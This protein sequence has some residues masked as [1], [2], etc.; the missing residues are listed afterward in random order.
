MVMNMIQTCTDQ[1]NDVTK[2]RHVCT[3][4][5]TFS[6]LTPNVDMEFN[7]VGELAAR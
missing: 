1:K 3:H 5:D 2:H 4:I 6:M 7:P